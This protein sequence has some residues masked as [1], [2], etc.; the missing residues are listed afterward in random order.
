MPHFR[1]QHSPRQIN[2]SASTILAL[3]RHASEKREAEAALEK[4]MPYRDAADG[5]TGFPISHMR[6][7]RSI[8]RRLMPRITNENMGVSREIWQGLRN[9]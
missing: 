6:S 4:A 3:G 2:H 5:D 7:T 1:F 9:S 8:A